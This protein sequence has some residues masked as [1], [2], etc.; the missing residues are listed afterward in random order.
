MF[1][2][3]TIKKKFEV[4]SM[5]VCRK[6]HGVVARRTDYRRTRFVF[7]GIRSTRAKPKISTA[8]T[9]NRIAFETV[10]RSYFRS[11]L[12]Y[13]ISLSRRLRLLQRRD[14]I[15]REERERR[16]PYIRV[17]TTVGIRVLRCVIKA[18]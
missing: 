14:N 4:F 16:G 10:F 17:L 18:Y 3:D 9:R 2:D 5:F 1:D 11:K 6:C 13:L 8:R 7:V 12:Y 15:M